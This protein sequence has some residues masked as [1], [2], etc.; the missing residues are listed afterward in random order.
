MLFVIKLLKYVVILLSSLPAI[1]VFAAPLTVSP[2]DDAIKRGAYI[3]R[4]GDC[5]ACHSAPGG[6]PMAGGLALSTPFGVIYSTN[7][8]PDIKTGIGRYSFVQ[9]D[10]AMRKGITAD[11]RNLYPAMPYPSFAKINA[12]DMRMLYAY[13]MH[14]VA[15]VSQVNKVNDMKW[16]FSMRSGLA[17]WNK[18]FLKDEP[19]KPDPA[20]SVQW[21]RGAYLIEG[22]GHCGSCHT[23]RGIAFQEKAMDQSGSDGKFFLA[24]STVAAW[25]AT[26]LRDLWTAAEIAQFLKAG[27]NSA[28][29]AYGSMT[30]VVHFSTQFFSDSDLM[31]MGEYLKSLPPGAGATLIRQKPVVN[32]QETADALYKTRGGLGY[33]QFCSTCHHLDG[34][35]VANIFPPLANNVSVLSKDPASVIHVVLSGWKSAQTQSS[36]RSF[37]MPNYSSFSNDELA[38]IVTFVRTKWG[39]QG[40]PVHAGQIQ[41]IR[42][43]IKLKPAAPTQFVVPRFAAMLTSRNAQQLVY[44]MRLM[45]ETNTLLPHN[46]GNSLN[47]ASC[48]LN[49][50]TVALGAPFVGLSAK[51]PIYAPRSGKIIDAKDRI[52]ACFRRSMNGTALPGDSAQMLAMVAYID[53]MKG[54][55]QPDD[56]IPGRGVGKISRNI[57]PDMKRGKQIYQNQCA[58]CHGAKGEGIQRAGGAY[59]F[60]P[61]WGNASFN[62]GAGMARTYTAAGFV[63]NN[64]PMA[65]T[66]SF[67]L[68]QGGL[69]VQEAVDVA[70]YFSHMPRPDYAAK[71]NDWPK[72]GKPKDARY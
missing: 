26:R 6:K 36:P 32:V 60:P 65:N 49:A 10:R 35:G 48:H 16:P 42:D 43:E 1:S 54:N 24:G 13:M 69:T 19:F 72:G 41:Q 17:V 9:F 21:N 71:A 4:L 62:I 50:G 22:L 14:G 56:P 63:K 59:I 46:V 55:T 45:L 5:V 44:G 51:F 39:N 8:T 37:G 64:M 67:P 58:V 18:V 3:S 20:Q 68:G 23:P 57:I 15:P 47:C 70:A 29:T 34:Q 2:A 30:E 38:E 40:E 31:A 28:A 12:Q 33:V 11:G 7:I 66:Q 52:N 25:H 53:W 61:L 27:H